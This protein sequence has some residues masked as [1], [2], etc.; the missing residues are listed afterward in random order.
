MGAVKLLS[1]GVIKYIIP[2]MENQIWYN[3]PKITIIKNSDICLCFFMN[4][5]P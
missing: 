3:L 5:L 2:K 1:L 4:L